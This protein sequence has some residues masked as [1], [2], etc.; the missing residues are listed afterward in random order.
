[1]RIRNYNFVLYCAIALSWLIV[2][3]ASA[4]T[5]SEFPVNLD[6][7][8]S[9][10]PSTPVPAT[11]EMFPRGYRTLDFQGQF[12]QEV[13]NQR[14][15]QLAGGSFGFDYYLLDRVAVEAD[16]PLYHVDRSGLPG[17]IAGGFT[18]LARLNFLEFDPWSVFIDGGAGAL[19]AGNRVPAYGTNFNFTPQAGF[20]FTYRLHDGVDL[21][22]GS[23]FFHLSNAGADGGN[24]N[25]GINGAMEGYAGLMFRF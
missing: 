25:P 8:P 23:H 3:A 15:D 9:T 7:D 12:I 13:T 6:I 22:A 20:G 18:L 16:F 4:Q 19:L 2:H 21:I 1:M 24:H 5:T 17:T 10:S 14:K 11:T